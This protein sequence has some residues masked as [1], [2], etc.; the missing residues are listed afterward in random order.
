MISI[1]KVN[2]QYS[3]KLPGEYYIGMSWDYCY[4]IFLDGKKIGRLFLSETV[5][6][7]M[8]VEWVELYKKFR[9]KGYLRQVIDCIEKEFPE[10]SCIEA[11]SSKD[12]I[13]KYE[14]I[15]FDVVAFDTLRE[16]Y[17]IQRRF[18]KE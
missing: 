13:E 17:S 4:N 15:G 16:M 10:K 5:T 8:F 14:R 3:A 7:S 1:S 11:E 2:I 9:G 12:N 18:K 6:D